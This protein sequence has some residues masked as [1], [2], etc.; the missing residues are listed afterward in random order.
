MVQI[1]H[2]GALFDDIT[3]NVAA[4]PECRVDFLLLGVIGADRGNEDSWANVVLRELLINRSRDIESSR[5][6]I[7]DRCAN[8]QS[9]AYLAPT[10]LRR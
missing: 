8:L 4:C 9:T 2:R 5:Q 3:N 6:F 1:T 10:P 7:P